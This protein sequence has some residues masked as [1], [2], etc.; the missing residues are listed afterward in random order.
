LTLDA[1]SRHVEAVSKR[2]AAAKKGAETRR[3]NATMKKE[4]RM[5]LEA[6]WPGDDADDAQV[7][8]HVAAMSSVF[9]YRLLQLDRW[10][11]TFMARF[12]ADVF[13]RARFSAEERAQMRREWHDRGLEAAGQM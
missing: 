9:G 6:T 2:S 7:V 8:V 1:A 10:S 4:A 11:G 12:L 3:R 13:A 5:I